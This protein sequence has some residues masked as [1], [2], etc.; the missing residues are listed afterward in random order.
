[1]LKDLTASS[2][3]KICL[4]SR[5]WLV[6]Q[7]AF[8]G[9]PGVKLEALTYGDIRKYIADRLGKN[10]R[11]VKLCSAEPEEA[12][13]LME[14]IVIKAQGVFLWVELVAKS[15]LSGLGNRD[16][17]SDLQKRLRLLPERVEDLYKVMLLRLDPFYRPRASQ[18]FQLVQV[19]QKQDNNAKHNTSGERAPLT[20]LKLAF[21][22]NEDA[23]QMA[24]D[25]P[26]TYLTNDEITSICESM[27]RKLKSRCAGLLET[28][29]SKDITNGSSRSV[30]YHSGSR[31]VYLHRTAKDFLESP[32]TQSLLLSW[33]AHAN[34]DCSTRMLAACVLELKCISL[35]S[36]DMWQS[37]ACAMA[38]AQ[39]AESHTAVSQS[40]LLDELDRSATQSWIQWRRVGP[41]REHPDLHWSHYI[42]IQYDGSSGP[43]RDSFLLYA[44]QHGLYHYIDSKRRKD[45]EC[46]TRPIRD[47][48]RKSST[49][50]HNTSMTQASSYGQF[51]S[52]FDTSTPK[53][54]SA[55]SDNPTKRELRMLRNSPKIKDYGRQ[56]STPSRLSRSTRRSMPTNGNIPDRGHEAIRHLQVPPIATSPLHQGHHT[57]ASG[58]VASE[59][60]RT[61]NQNRRQSELISSERAAEHRIPFSDAIH[62][63]YIWSDKISPEASTPRQVPSIS[64]PE[65][66]G[67]RSSH[68]QT[69]KPKT[70]SHPAITYRDISSRPSTSPKPAMNPLRRFWSR[71]K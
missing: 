43:C 14:E 56:N 36:H 67:I 4:S 61:N 18:I 44:S 57:M 8:H 46:F 45:P 62:S 23:I 65:G 3:V 17:I 55:L 71:H 59:W 69:S 5:P 37:I 9:L 27:D 25:S 21:A 66:R 19:A 20:V 52:S 49:G 7:D 34:F 68:Q 42:P 12:P 24:I 48:L 32:D 41:G 47:A 38:F 54:S 15:L 31:V 51:S 40:D 16:R 35:G 39:D 28:S 53:R 33:N 30:H 70:P 58:N 10:P 60:I 22:D 6:F 50:F 11:M 26:I 2:N 29:E 63:E 64:C 1:M 13:K